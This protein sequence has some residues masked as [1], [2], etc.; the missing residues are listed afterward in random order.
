MRCTEVG[1][2]GI[3]MG[4]PDFQITFPPIPESLFQAKTDQS[5]II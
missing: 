5:P 4:D 3:T 1:D 2:E